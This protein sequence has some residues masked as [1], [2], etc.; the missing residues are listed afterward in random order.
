MTIFEATM[1]LAS[2][3]SFWATIFTYIAYHLGNVGRNVPIILFFVFI[4]STITLAV[5]E[6]RSAPDI[7]ELLSN[8]DDSKHYSELH[9]KHLREPE[10]DE[11]FEEDE[12]E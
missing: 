12:T 11:E 9:P 8:D 3:C 7:D 4:V 2:L 10:E 5:Y 1:Y 6:V